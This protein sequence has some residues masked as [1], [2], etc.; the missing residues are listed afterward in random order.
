[1]YLALFR[2]QDAFNTIIIYNEDLEVVQEYLKP[3]IEEASKDCYRSE[4][5]EFPEKD[6][7]DSISELWEF[8][9]RDEHG[10]FMSAYEIHNTHDYFVMFRKDGNYVRFPN[11]K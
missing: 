10:Q 2:S 8:E 1:M 11:M 5:T 7:V 6:R 4:H 9:Y 3:F